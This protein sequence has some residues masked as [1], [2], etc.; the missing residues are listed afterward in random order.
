[1]GLSDLLGFDGDEYAAKLKDASNEE[2]LINE[3]MKRREFVSSGGSSESVHLE[4]DVY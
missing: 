3:R 1:M 4:L 2:L